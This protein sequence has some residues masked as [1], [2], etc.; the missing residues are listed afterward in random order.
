MFFK[1]IFNL[2]LRRMLFE[3]AKVVILRHITKNI[4]GLVVMC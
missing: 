4:G 1:S 3:G 2:A